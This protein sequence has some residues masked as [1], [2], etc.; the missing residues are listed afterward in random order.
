MENE[1]RTRIKQL[2]EEEVL[3]EIARISSGVLTDISLSL[4]K[5]LRQKIA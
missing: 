5:Q 1:T 4:A 3:N 2:S